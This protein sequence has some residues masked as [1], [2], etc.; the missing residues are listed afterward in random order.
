MVKA[1]SRSKRSLRKAPHSTAARRSRLVAA[2]TRTPRDSAAAPSGQEASLLWRSS[3]TADCPSAG[4]SAASFKKRV[5]P[6]PSSLSTP[7]ATPVYQAKKPSAP[8]LLVGRRIN[9]RHS[10]ARNGLPDSGLPWWIEQAAALL[11]VPLSPEINIGASVSPAR[12]ICRESSRIGSE[13]PS[14]AGEQEAPWLISSDMVW[15]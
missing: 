7:S 5:P 8:L 12:A 10:I 13:A 15:R 14:R 2:I 6:H 1:A 9:E 3:Q 4:R 11:P